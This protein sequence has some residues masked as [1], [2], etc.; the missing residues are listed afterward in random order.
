MKA[1]LAHLA[2]GNVSFFNE[3]SCHVCFQ[4]AMC[5]VGRLKC[6]KFTDNRSGEL[7]KSSA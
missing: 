1:F 7:K 4:W 3:H 6:E 2:K 5:F